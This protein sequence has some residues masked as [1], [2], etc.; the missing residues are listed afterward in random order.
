M[1]IIPKE[2]ISISINDSPKFPEAK[3]I[4][5]IIKNIYRN[6][7]KEKII[8]NTKLQLRKDFHIT[9]IGNKDAP[10]LKRQI[11]EKYEER[12]LTK[13]YSKIKEDIKNLIKTSP[14]KF[15]NKY[16]ILKKEYPEG[17]RISIIQILE[18]KIL[19]K[20]RKLMEDK[21]KIKISK[22]SPIPHITI[23]KQKHNLG[24]G[25]YEKDDLKEYSVKQI[26]I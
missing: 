17:T 2:N 22:T 26:E 13:T 9:L 8:E 3:N 25:L 21:Y 14:I 10:K 11:I 12:N 24:I 7:S 16:Y 1:K 4:L 20:F 5:L 6:K 23:Y 18:T 15:T 19:E